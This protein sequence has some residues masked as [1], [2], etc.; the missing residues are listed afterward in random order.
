MINPGKE[1]A[2]LRKEKGL[3]LKALAEFAGT[4]PKYIGLLVFR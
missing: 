2:L 4:N 1:F 3:T